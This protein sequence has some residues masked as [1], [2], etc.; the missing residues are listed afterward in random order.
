MPDGSPLQPE[1]FQFTTEEMALAPHML[2]QLIPDHLKHVKLS[3]AMPTTSQPP[4]YVPS[5]TSSSATTGETTGGD[6]SI[7]G[8]MSSL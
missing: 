4:Y 7:V 8:A 2:D 3:S 5:T 6:S 1:L